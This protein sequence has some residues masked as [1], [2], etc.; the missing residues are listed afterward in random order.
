LVR[1]R[2]GLDVVFLGPDGAGK[3]TVIEGVRGQLAEAFSGVFL[4]TVAPSLS[5]LRDG[6]YRTRTTNHADPRAAFPHQFP[7]QPLL[8]SLVKAAYWL[9]YYVLGYH[10]TVRP[11]LARASLVLHH[12]YLVDVLVD[13]RRY[14]YGGPE[15]V[16]RLLWRLTPKPDLVILLDAPPEVIRARKTELPTAEIGRQRAAYLSLV[17]SMT[18]GHVLDAAHRPERTIREATDL[19][20]RFMAQ[21]TARQLGRG[22]PA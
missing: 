2:H 6:S 7:P 20:L 19:V 1:P 21:R 12:R 15:W 5:Q 22:S 10:V 14:R 11:A 3:S 16:L 4:Q 17:E 18:N 9:V 13:P 8:L